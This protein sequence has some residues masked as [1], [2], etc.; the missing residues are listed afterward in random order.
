MASVLEL[1]CE[2]VG[3]DPRVVA[4]IGRRIESA[5]RD[6]DK[7]GIRLFCGSQCSLRAN[8]GHERLLI[9]ADLSLPG[10]DGGDG[11]SSEAEDGYRRGE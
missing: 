4:A 2:K 9:L 6:A 3:I 10:A 11:G 5:C 1:E 7:R 8:D